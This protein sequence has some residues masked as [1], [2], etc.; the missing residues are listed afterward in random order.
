MRPLRVLHLV[1]ALGLGGIERV[2]QSLAR[3][4]DR[5]RLEIRVVCA[6]RGGPL[7]REIEEEG[8]P[9][10]VLGL[11]SY[12]PGSLVTA[13]LLVAREPPDV[14][15]SHGHFA[16]V[17]ARTAAFC[18]RVPI[19]VH[20]LHTIDTTLRPRHLRLERAL[21]RVTS[22]ILCCSR[23]VEAHAAEVV[24][25]PRAL[26]L[27][28]PNG[29]DPAPAGGRPE[30]LR[31]LGATTPPLVGCLGSLAPHKG[32]EVLLRA[33]ALLALEA[34]PPTVVLIGDGPDRASLE[35]IAAEAGIAD[36]VLFV[37][38]RTDARR[39]LPAM[40]LV[41]VPSLER[42]G[43]G[44]AALEAM[45]AGRPVVASRVGGLVE[46]VEEG[47]TGLLVS[48]GDPGALASA[49]RSILDRPERGKSLGE[50]G[51]LR[52]DAHF[53]AAAMARRVAA[54]YEEELRE[55]RAA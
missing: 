11:R 46:V 54:V 49:I 36:R 33:C 47:R 32:Q 19:V 37:G 24:G 42:E 44:L 10:R 55:R 7:A 48:P 25:L 1:E 3:H 17:I 43:L 52:I 6:S 34:R 35:R 15:H 27:T 38:E 39:L 28:V 12:Y 2:V 51:R 41:V 18:A 8:T 26:L 23:A 29:V 31:L 9:V 14:I 50:A 45:D 30:A 20:H 13:A 21:A 4:A 5:R 53:R 22:R 40:D 16:G